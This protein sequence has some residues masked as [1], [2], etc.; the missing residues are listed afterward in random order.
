MQFRAL[1][2]PVEGN[3]KRPT[4]REGFYTSYRFVSHTACT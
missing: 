2:I 1:L 4:Y 3:S